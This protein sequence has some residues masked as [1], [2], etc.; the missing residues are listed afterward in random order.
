MS[1]SLSLRASISSALVAASVRGPHDR[2]PGEQERV[3]VGTPLAGVCDRRQPRSAFG[4]E[5]ERELV[6]EALHPQQRRDMGLQEYAPRHVEQVAEP[7][8]GKVIGLVAHPV[9]KGP[10]GTIDA[11]VR[12][13]G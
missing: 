2:E 1:S 13:N 3:G 4:Q 7:H 8:P 12:T 5:I 11:A 6:E 9:R 10:I